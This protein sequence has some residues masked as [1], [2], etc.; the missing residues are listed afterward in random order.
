MFIA[1]L[2]CLSHSLTIHPIHPLS[3]YPANLSPSNSN[4]NPTTHTQAS[5]LTLLSHLVSIEHNNKSKTYSLY[6]LVTPTTFHPE[7]TSQEVTTIT[8][9]SEPFLTTIM[10]SPSNHSLSSTPSKITSTHNS[11]LPPLP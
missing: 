7:S 5:S 10:T 4:V 9:K 6:N 11:N 8:L 3:P 2:L 1:K